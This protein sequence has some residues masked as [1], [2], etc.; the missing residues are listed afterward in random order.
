[1]GAFTIEDTEVHERDAGKVFRFGGELGESAM[2]KNAPPQS[3]RAG[4]V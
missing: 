4:R 1:M 2:G 3:P